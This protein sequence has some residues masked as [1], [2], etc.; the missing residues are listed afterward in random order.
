MGHF[1]DFVLRGRFPSRKSPGKQPFLKKRGIKRFLIL[2]CRSWVE[3][4]RIK[5]KMQM[6]IKNKVEMEA[7]LRIV[8]ARQTRAQQLEGRNRSLF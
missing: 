4:K 7:M 2:R 3:S 8:M 6:K 1:P 5:M